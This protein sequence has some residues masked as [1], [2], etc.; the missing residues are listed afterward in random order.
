MTT[1]QGSINAGSG[2]ANDSEDDDLVSAVR[3]DLIVAGASRPLDDDSTLLVRRALDMLDAVRQLL[4]ALSPSEI[5][6]TATRVYLGRLDG[7]HEV[8]WTVYG[9]RH[10]VLTDVFTSQHSAFAGLA[11]AF[12][13]QRRPSRTDSRPALDDARKGQP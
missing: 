8:V 2:G 10:Q 13:D 1:P 7:Q 6:A 5:Q 11:R 3:R 4:R 9:R 12:F